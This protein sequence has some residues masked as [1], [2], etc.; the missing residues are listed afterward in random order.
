MSEAATQSIIGGSMKKAKS[1]FLH[2]G[3]FGCAY[4]PPIPCKKSRSRH[5]KKTKLVG[6]ILPKTDVETELSLTTL[7]KTIPH[8]EDYYIIPEEDACDARNFFLARDDV[9]GE[10]KL[11]QRTKDKNLAQLISPYGGTALHKLSYGTNFKYL[12]SLKHL[13]RAVA[14][15]NDAG[16]VHFDL[17]MANVLSDFQGK[18]RIIDFGISFALPNLTPTMIDQRQVE[19]SPGYAV[20]APDLTLQ[21]AVYD[22]VNLNVALEMIFAEKKVLHLAASVLGLG[23]TE[24]KENLRRFC[25]EDRSMRERNW[26]LF[27]KTHAFKWDAWCVGMIF[28]Y[29][30]QD[31]LV[32]T[33][34]VSTIWNVHK[35]K[36]RAV[37]RAL[38]RAD[39]RQRATAAQALAY[40]S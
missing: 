13:L 24:Q 14:Q 7:I 3:S 17:H 22:N 20:E 29:I 25:Y 16:I 27:Y 31:L 34:F 10:C 15:L 40:L 36:I 37:L 21:R 19:F 26:L 1:T 5:S 4:T 30:L 32:Q 6:K 18:L 8:Y 2:E 35:E 23:L 12:E 38:L 39:P 11:F 9:A 28:M 33:W